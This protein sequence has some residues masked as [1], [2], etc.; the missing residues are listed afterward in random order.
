[1]YNQPEVALENYEISITKI[2]KG[3]GVYVC[4][5]NKG[6]KLLVPYRGHEERAKSLRNV[7]I[8]IQRNGMDVEQ[9]ALNGEGNVISQDNCETSYILKDYRQG[10]EC[11]TQNM[12]DMCGGMRALAQFHN[13]MSYYPE[14]PAAAAVSLVEK[15]GRKCAQIVKL[16]NYIRHRGKTNR[17]EHLF[18]QCYEHFL[19][20]GQKS[21]EIIREIEGS[22]VEQIPLIYCHGDFNHH[23]VICTPSGRWI[24]INFE[25]IQPGYPEIDIAE[26]MRKMLEKNLWQAETGSL[27]LE[28]YEQVRKL[29]SAEIKLL[30]ALLIFPEKFCKLCNHYSNSRKSWVCDRDVEKLEL[31][32]EQNEK[33]ELYLQ[34]AF[35]ILRY[36]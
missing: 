32:I 31:L 12:E 34:S 18:G 21:V 6:Q 30:A 15:N 3:R 27:L 19:A 4:D 20:Q 17:F 33:R 23:N 14:K 10:R 2:A 5:T 11:S 35:D 9:V 1:M 13:I 24:P 26:Y 16:K 36:D 28:S 25:T 29:S 22:S 8:Y 7:L